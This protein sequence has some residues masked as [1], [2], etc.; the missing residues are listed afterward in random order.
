MKSVAFILVLL[1]ATSAVGQ[2][3]ITE[4]R[5]TGE[6]RIV[7][8]EAPDAAR[9]LALVDAQRKVW[10]QA[11]TQLQ[12]RANIRTLQL[13]TAQL[14]AYTAVLLE[15]IEQPSDAVARGTSPVY[16]VSVLAAMNGEDL[17]GRMAALRK[18]QDA[19]FELLAAWTQLQQ[20]QDGRSF[21][22]RLLTA[23]ASAAVARTQPSTIGGR[24]P[25]PEGRQRARALVDEALALAPDSP[26]AHYG[27]GD[28][29]IDAQQPVPAEAAYR[30]GLSAQ[31][32]SSEGHRRLAEALR[33]QDKL[34]EAEGELRE[35]LR[36]EPGSAR[37]YCDLGLVLRGQRN[38]SDATAAFREAIR[39]DPD[40]I[41]AHNNL[42]IVLA[43]E[44]RWPDAA[45]EFREMI[46]IDPDS[47]TAYYNLATVLADLDQDVESAAALR[48]VIRIN[49][50]HY[51]AHYN[52]GELFR[53]EGKYHDSAKQFREFLRLAP[54]D[55]PASRRNIERA[56]GFVEKFEDP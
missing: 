16:K 41:D 55:T 45:A 19:T 29:L 50:N 10:R 32:G 2:R 52:L 13:K 48:E 20:P 7:D 44:R 22:A 46:R 5:A 49:P 4:L 34:D 17:A 28:L 39:L 1:S 6:H 25:S 18:D 51:N 31:P 36:L 3:T 23:K 12:S 15:A 26:Y 24:A 37:A 42:A 53:L 33:L 47:A 56:K 40:L 54:G 30:K 43:G 21:T 35:A 8:G 11:V 38:T 27:L 9:L 14:E